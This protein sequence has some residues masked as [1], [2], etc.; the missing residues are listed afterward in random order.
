MAEMLHLPND[1]QGKKI[2]DQFETKTY[3]RNMYLPFIDTNDQALIKKIQF[4]GKGNETE[5]ALHLPLAPA[6]SIG[7]DQQVTGLGQRLNIQNKKVSL[8]EIAAIATV[9]TSPFYEQSTTLNVFQQTKD[10]LAV[11]MARGIANKIT[12]KHTTSLYDVATEI[13]SRKRSVFGNGTYAAGRGTAASITAGFAA[14]QADGAGRETDKMTLKHIRRLQ[15]KATSGLAGERGYI[16][17]NPVTSFSGNSMKERFGLVLMLTTRAYNQLLADEEYRNYIH[18]NREQNA[19][20]GIDGMMF[21][22]R[23]EG[24]DIYVNP[25]LDTIEVATA[26]AADF[27]NSW[28][29]LLGAS[30]ALMINASGENGREI[31]LSMDK[32]NAGRLTTVIASSMVGIEVPKLRVGGEDLELGIVHSFTRNA[33]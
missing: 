9:S 18:Y 17:L 14:L 25:H 20:N 7:A 12:D 23:V 5:V 22:G 33:R 16:N 30:S 21:K 19:P 32:T 10:N 29:L 26:G 15:Q 8:E 13:P 6:T 3:A 1:L 11:S 24:I 31:S 27:V 28:S 4:N 2:Y